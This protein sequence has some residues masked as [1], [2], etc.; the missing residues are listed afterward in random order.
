MAL[1]SGSWLWI[2]GSGLWILALDPGSEPRIREPWLR[3]SNPGT[4][5][6]KIW[7]PRIS[8][9]EV[10]F[11]DARSQIPAKGFWGEKHPDSIQSMLTTLG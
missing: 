6:I 7:N 8:A 10:R 4:R 11:T 1:V 9:L 5:D 2:H 3:A